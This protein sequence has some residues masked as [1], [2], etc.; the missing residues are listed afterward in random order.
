[1]CAKRWWEW[2][3]LQAY[4]ASHLGGHLSEHFDVEFILSTWVNMSK[5][6]E[7]ARSKSRIASDLK[8]RDSNRW[9]LCDLKP[10]F[11]TRDWRFV[12]NI[13]IQQNCEKGCDL[14]PRSKIASDWRLAILPTWVNM[15][16]WNSF[17][18]KS[19]QCF[20][21]SRKGLQFGCCEPG[22]LPKK[23]KFPKV[24]RGGCKMSFWLFGPREQRSPKSLLHHPNPLLHRCNPISHQCKRPLARGVQKTFCTLS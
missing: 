14:S 20:S 11:E 17:C 1:M 8:T 6:G 24:V 19:L 15:L 18:L 13:P 12:L 10:R 5:M 4:I 23:G 7:I 3:S 9:C 22:N 16:M 21:R 2:P